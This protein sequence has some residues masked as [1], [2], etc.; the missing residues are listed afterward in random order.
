MTWTPQPDTYFAP[1]TRCSH[2]CGRRPVGTVTVAWP[3]ARDPEESYPFPA[4]RE[5]GEAV[6]FG[7][8]RPVH[9]VAVRRP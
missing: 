7:H 3:T 4:C 9:G 5:C 1:A 6:G 8:P 2:G